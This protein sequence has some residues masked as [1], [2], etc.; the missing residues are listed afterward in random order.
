MPKRR[1]IA[2]CGLSNPLSVSWTGLPQY[3]EFDFIRNDYNVPGYT[4]APNQHLNF[5]P[6]SAS[7]YNGIFI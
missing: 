1:A 7:S 4:Q 2:S 6:K 5:V 3:N